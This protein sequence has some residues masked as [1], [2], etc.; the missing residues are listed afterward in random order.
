MQAA[1]AVVAVADDEPILFRLDLRGASGKLVQGNEGAPGQ[2]REVVLPLLPHVEEERLLAV[3]EPL[4]QI[5]NGH[6]PH[7]AGILRMRRGSW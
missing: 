6:L 1:H 2:S 5:L 7:P 3:R 4:R